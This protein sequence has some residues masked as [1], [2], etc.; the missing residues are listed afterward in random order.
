M[1][2]GGAAL[3]RIDAGAPRAYTAFHSVDLVKGKTIRDVNEL[4]VAT[5]L[6]R[7]P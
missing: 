4:T 3:A 7:S 1:S 2:G 6:R 5:D